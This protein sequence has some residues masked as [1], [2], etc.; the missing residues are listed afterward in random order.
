MKYKL[1]VLDMDGTL[2]NSN[3][4]VSIENKK[5]L[6]KAQDSGIQVAIATGRIFTS[7][8]FY[9][10]LLGITAPIIACNGAL[11]RDQN[12]NE[13]IDINPIDKEDALK[14]I[15]VFK[16]YN[17]YFHIYDEEKIYVEK[18]GFSSSIY[19]AW[20]EDQSDENKI[21][22]E[23]LED[24][25][26][27]F[28]SNNINIL[29]LMAVDDDN[30]K[31]DTIRK[32]LEGINSITIDK[33]WHNNLEVM[34]KGVSKGKGIEMLTKIYKVE[35]EEIIAFGDNFNDLS[36]K[37]YVG[38]FVAMGNGEEYVKKQADYVT[39]SNDDNG[40]AKG[41]E[42]LVLNITNKF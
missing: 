13:V 38:T 29:K 19:S 32:E 33:S 2:L 12:S 34:S 5:A 10:R 27:Y 6:K 1:I 20:N 26:G 31:M 9:A 22:I 41:I 25:I 15:E 40:V 16:K 37:H 14:V 39:T 3:K 18:L 30:T 11:V 4:E 35:P 36:M 42:K 23:K 21:P 7:A 28:K 24:T 8:R 17:V